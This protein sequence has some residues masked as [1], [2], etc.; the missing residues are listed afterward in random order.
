MFTVDHADEVNVGDGIS[1]F[2]T[3]TDETACP[4]SKCVIKASS[5]CSATDLAADPDLT[6][7][8]YTGENIKIG[9]EAPFQVSAHAVSAD[10]FY[11]QVCIVCKTGDELTK[12]WQGAIKMMSECGSTI[13]TRKNEI[14]HKRVSPLEDATAVNVIAAD[15]FH[16]FF[17]F[18][19][20]NQCQ[21]KIVCELRAQGCLSPYTGT[22]LEIVKDTDTGKWK[23]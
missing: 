12:P 9:A 1:N 21:D 15:T 11:Q 5:A 14:D 6:K 17:Q 2:F 18:Q 8:L 23:T 22:Y 13:M 16:T 7:N 19:Y 3:N 4:F 20:E 10:Y